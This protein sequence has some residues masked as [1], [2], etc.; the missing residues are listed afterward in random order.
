MQPNDYAIAQSRDDGVIQQH[1]LYQQTFFQLLHIM[2]P[3]MAEPLLKDTP[4]A[5]VHRIQI[6]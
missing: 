3:R 2:D 6:W 1:P 4:D 5:V